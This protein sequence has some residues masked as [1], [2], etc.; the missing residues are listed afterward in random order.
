MC[1]FQNNLA[2][3]CLKDNIRNILYIFPLFTIT[4]QPLENKALR[5]FSKPFVFS[6]LR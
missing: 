3:L 6:I 1:I 4:A 5:F 2:Y